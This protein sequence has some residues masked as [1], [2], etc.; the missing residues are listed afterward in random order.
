MNERLD[1]RTSSSQSGAPCPV[2][3]SPPQGRCLEAEI[4]EAA[5]YA[6]ILDLHDGLVQNLFAAFSQAHSLRQR[7]AEVDAGPQAQALEEGLRRIGELIEYSLQEI[8]SFIGA[9]GSE[10]L[11]DQDLGTMVEG[12]AVQREDL[13]GMR[14]SVQVED[15]LPPVSLP[16]K[17]AVYRILQEAFSNAYRHGHAT[18]Q[19]VHLSCQD[20]QL[21]L[22]VADNGQGFDPQVVLEGRAHSAGHLGLRGMRDRVH[23]LGGTFHLQ[24]APGQGTRIQVRI[25][26]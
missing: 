4:S 19:H 6:L 12:L 17:I 25:P 1:Q 16:V 5:L 10:G 14:I 3:H 24:S 18:H 15:E 8:R 2:C 9:F 26:L 23:M 7:I 21:R 13:T 20:D 22:E 11:E